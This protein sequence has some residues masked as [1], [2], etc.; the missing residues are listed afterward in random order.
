VLNANPVEQ[1]LFPFWTES[2]TH[3]WTS[4][5]SGSNPALR[6]SVIAGCIPGHWV[7]GL[8]APHCKSLNPFCQSGHRR[9]Y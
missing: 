9:S 6:S 4:S 7:S 2:S 5:V 8:H 3:W 1:F